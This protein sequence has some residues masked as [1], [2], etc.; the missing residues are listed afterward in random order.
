L[1]RCPVV[2]HV[3]HSLACC[4]LFDICQGMSGS[5]I[6]R[7]SP[8]ARTTGLRVGKGNGYNHVGAVNAMPCAILACIFNKMSNVILVNSKTVCNELIL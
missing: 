6:P 5:G 4:K 3:D 1:S 7:V 8:L 2:C